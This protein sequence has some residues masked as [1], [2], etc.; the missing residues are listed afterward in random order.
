MTWQRKV[1]GFA[2][3]LFVLA[4]LLIPGD[5]WIDGFLGFSF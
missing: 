2:A 4:V 3:A 5:N 1:Q